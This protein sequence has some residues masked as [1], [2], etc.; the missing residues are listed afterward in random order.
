[1]LASIISKCKYPWYLREGTKELY[2]HPTDLWKF[3]FEPGFVGEWAIPDDH[4]HPIG[5][6]GM[7][8]GYGLFRQDDIQILLLAILEGEKN[9]NTN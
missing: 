1:M 2:L 4:I 5:R 8:Y 3:Q 9:E 6:F 7:M